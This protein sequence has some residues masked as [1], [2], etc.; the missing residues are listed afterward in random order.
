MQKDANDSKEMCSRIANAWKLGIQMGLK[1]EED[2][3]HSLRDIKLSKDYNQVSLRE[4]NKVAHAGDALADAMLFRTSFA[5]K[6]FL[7]K[8]VYGG[9]IDLILNH[10]KFLVQALIIH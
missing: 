8:E 3:S 10:C 4:S 2:F 9:Q 6:E 7:F 1:L 5:P